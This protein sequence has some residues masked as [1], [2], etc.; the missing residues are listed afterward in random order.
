MHGSVVWLTGLSGSGKSTIARAV[1][2]ELLKQ[3]VPVEVL[4]G[5]AIREKL[6]RGLGFSKQDRDENVRRVGYVAQL[7]ARHGVVVVVALIS[8]Y[9]ALRDEV[10][11]G[12]NGI[13]FIEVYVNAPLEVC[14]ARDTKGLYQKARRGEISSF[15]GV[16]D[17]YEA[18]V[19]AEVECRTDRESVEL[20]AGR[21]LIALAAGTGPA[22]DGRGSER[23][24]TK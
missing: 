7:L 1:A 20:S 18:P 24:E 6:S 13:L 21:V 3:G 23:S 2:Q 22:P 5:D 12:M 11:G 19:S 10:R 15:T 17:P 9:R 14:E 8:P 4:D 16:D